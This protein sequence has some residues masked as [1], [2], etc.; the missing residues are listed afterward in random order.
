MDKIRKLQKNNWN[1]IYSNDEEIKYD[2]W[3]YLTMK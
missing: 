3:I 2:G 1:V